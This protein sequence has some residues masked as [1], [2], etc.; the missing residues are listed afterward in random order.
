M[1]CLL[2]PACNL[3]EVLPFFTEWGSVGYDTRKWQSEI[4]NNKRVSSVLQLLIWGI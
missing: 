3:L 1:V 2:V 4:M